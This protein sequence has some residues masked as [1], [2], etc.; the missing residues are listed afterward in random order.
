MNASARNTSVERR[1]ANREVF[2]LVEVAVQAEPLHVG[3]VQFI[4]SD[5]DGGH[6][7]VQGRTV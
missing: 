1:G 4:K 3:V 2:A 7:R 5:T 6:R